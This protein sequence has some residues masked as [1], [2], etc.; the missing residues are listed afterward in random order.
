MQFSINGIEGMRLSSA[1]KLG[2]GAGTA[3]ST[4]HVGSTGASNYTVG[5][6]HV[7]MDLYSIGNPLMS[8]VGGTSAALGQICWRK[9][10]GNAAMGF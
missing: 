9:P 1:G 10:N 4:L 5:G 7:G 6:V 8:L 3:K 2:I